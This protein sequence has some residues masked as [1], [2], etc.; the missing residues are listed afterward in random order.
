MESFHESPSAKH[1]ADIYARISGYPPLLREDNIKL[2]APADALESDR[3]KP[4]IIEV[5]GGRLP[6]NVKPVIKANAFTTNTE[7][8]S[9]ENVVSILKD[10]GIEVEN[11]IKKKSE[12]VGEWIRNYDGP[13]VVLH[14]EVPSSQY[15]IHRELAQAAITPLTEYQISQYQICLWAGIIFVAV[16]AA[17]VCSIIQME[18]VPDS[19]LF[20]KF[21]S[22]RTHKND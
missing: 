9:L 4:A 8:P 11:S 12:E 17:A 22:S 1:V 21:I 3:R 20:A 18:V 10:H 16:A 13:V 5:Y 19:L 7:R 14:H 6:D 2:P 15:Y